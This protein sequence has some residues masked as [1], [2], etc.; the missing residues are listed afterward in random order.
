MLPLSRKPSAWVPIAMSL[1]I[2]AMLLYHLLIIGE[3]R[4]D[5][6]GTAAHIFQLWLVAEVFIVGYFLARWVPQQPKEGTVIL[7]IQILT[8]LLSIGP[9]FYF[10]L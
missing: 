7:V 4:E 3:Q 1:A 5:D 10:Q 9:V 6:E 8:A 2:F